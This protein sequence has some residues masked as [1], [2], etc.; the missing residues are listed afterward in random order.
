MNVQEVIYRLALVEDKTLPVELHIAPD[1]NTRSAYIEDTLDYV[2][3][4]A[5][6]VVL[7]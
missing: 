3:E 2:S 4:H 7:S 5:D 6:K 1:L